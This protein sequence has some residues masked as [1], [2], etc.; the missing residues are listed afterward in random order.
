MLKYI[1]KKREIYSKILI[2]F[3]L[4]IIINRLVNFNILIN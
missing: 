2:V 3:L 1:Y 4:G